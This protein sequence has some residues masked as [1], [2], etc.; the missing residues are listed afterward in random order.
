MSELMQG[1]LESK[2][3]T[4]PLYPAGHEFQI[5]ND[6]DG[7]NVYGLGLGRKVEIYAYLTPTQAEEMAAVLL[8]RAKM[9]REAHS[10]EFVN[11][12][13]KVG[14]EYVRSTT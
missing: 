4:D 7:I 5:F 3:S 13:E 12:L 10:E 2:K 1:L 6:S 11:E 8:L 14:H 9:F